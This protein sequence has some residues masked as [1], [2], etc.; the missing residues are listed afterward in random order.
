MLQQMVEIWTTVRYTNAVFQWLDQLREHYDWKWM[1]DRISDKRLSTDELWRCTCGMIIAFGVVS[2]F[3]SGKPRTIL[4]F[5]VWKDY[6]SECLVAQLLRYTRCGI[7]DFWALQPITLHQH[8]PISTAALQYRLFKAKKER[9]IVKD[10][11]QGNKLNNV[12]TKK[13]FRL[14]EQN[15]YSLVIADLETVGF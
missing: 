4:A 5:S 11:L 13:I 10:K 15:K 8:D 6:S 1:R 2:L 3:A 9:E 12:K 7:R 14:Q